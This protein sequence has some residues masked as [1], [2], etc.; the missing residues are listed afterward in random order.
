MENSLKGNSG[1]VELIGPTDKNVLTVY[2]PLDVFGKRWAF[3][4]EK[5]LEEITSPVKSM[6][7][8]IS[9][10]A[11]ILFVIV[12]AIGLM[13]ARVISSP[14]A[15]ANNNLTSVSSDV[16]ENSEK[17]KS[18]SANLND[19]SGELSSSIQ[20]T[21]TTMDELTQ[22]VNKNLDN[23]EL[24]SNMS[25]SSQNV[26]N[27]GLATVTTMLEAMNQINSTN[28]NISFE[29]QQINTQME[30]IISVIQEIAS[31]TTVIN[32]IVFQTKLLSFNASV[33][34][35]RA[36]EHGKGF[37]VVAEEV[38]NLATA[39]GS[40]A[41]EISEMLSN[42]V[43]KVQGIIEMTKSKV[44]T[45]TKGSKE[46]VEA[47]QKV[48]QECGEKLQEIL[49]NVNEVNKT[50]SEV[51][52]ASNEQA[53][54]IKEVSKAMQRLDQVCSDTQQIANEVFTISTVLESGS[55]KLYTI[56]EGLDGLVSGKD[57]GRTQNI[58]NA[59]SMEELENQPPQK[60]DVTEFSDEDFEDLDQYSDENKSD[61]NK[62][63]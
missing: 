10:G 41:T 1:I 3:I 35:A 25:Q 32:D 56:V 4:A 63:A 26:A 53:A 30:E 33:E 40:A 43:S 13:V 39:S 62:I 16:S 29:M 47:G 46:K 7:I 22:M 11:I 48:A 17:I 38:G 8:F 23:I 51:K 12:L 60:H 49:N 34:A 57:T 55:E 20:E 36:G 27:D 14:I 19:Y 52:L 5:E 9:I 45:A 6:V 58:D 2:G 24:T 59:T 61:P 28:E 44:E 21:V 31:K 54:G 18:Y 50:V 37:S 15:N 42:S